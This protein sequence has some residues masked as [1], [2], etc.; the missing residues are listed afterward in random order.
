VVTKE[1]AESQYWI[2]LMIE[3][4]QGSIE[5]WTAL[6]DES[7]QLLRIFVAS[8]RTARQSRD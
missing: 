8:G 2:E 5:Q 6:L 3:S 7:L 4:R 1:A